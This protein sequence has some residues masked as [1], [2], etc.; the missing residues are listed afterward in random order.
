M[1][2]FSIIR[3]SLLAIS[4]LALSLILWL[5]VS[6]WYDAYLQRIDASDLLQGITLDDNLFRLSRDLS[7]ER[8]LIHIM[9][10]DSNSNHAVKKAALVE[11]QGESF[12]HYEQVLRDISI[13]L[14]TRSLVNRL[15]FKPAFVEE[16]VESL[17]SQWKDLNLKRE[18][19]LTQLSM[20]P[21]DR[22]ENLRQQVFKQFTASIDATQ[23]VKD[24]LRITQR[25]TELSIDQLETL[26][27]ANWY[28]GEDIASEASIISGIIL[29]GKRVT[30]TQLQMIKAIHS[31]ALENWEELNFYVHKQGATS[32]LVD[33]I[34]RIEERYFVEYI[35]LRDKILSDYQTLDSTP[36]WIDQWLFVVKRMHSQLDTLDEK[37]SLEV[38]TNSQEVE[39]HAVRR[40]IIDT[41]LV[42]ICLLI[43]AAVVATLKRIQHMAT[44]DALTGLPNRIRFE[45]LLDHEFKERKDYRIGVI[46]LDVYGFKRVNDRLGHSIGDQ[47]LMQVAS[48]LAKSTESGIVLA[49]LG[50]DEFAS[51]VKIYDDLESFT[52]T[53]E[54]YISVLAREFEVEGT[55][56]QIGS[57]IGL[58]YSSDDTHSA[59]EL[60]KNADFAM[61]QAK[62]HGKDC[63][64]LFDQDI[65]DKY[66]Y[67]IQLELE[68]R[69]AVKE[70]QFQLYYQPQFNVQTQKIDAV[71]A[72]IRWDHPEK[73]LVAPD[74]FLPLAEET[75]LLTVIG[76]W[77]LDEA[78]RQ[79]SVWNKGSLAG[80][81]IAANVSAAH[82]SRPGFVEY[83]ESTY[84]KHNIDP[85]SLELEI[86]ESALVDNME[87]VIETFNSLRAMNIELAID[88]FG[89]G[90][91]S[92]SYLQDL[93]VD[94]LKIDKS[95]IDRLD[96]DSEN[97]IA[98][99]IVMLAKACG[100]K[101]VAEGVE[102]ERQRSQISEFGC[103][104]IQGYFYSKPMESSKVPQKIAE[105]NAL[106]YSQR[107]A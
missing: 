52:N 89:T 33:T 78:C 101:T 34:G 65:S 11:L 5:S 44:H 16:Q 57:C 23:L 81:R 77:V 13:A 12:N 74:V 24:K 29:L 26:R 79:I 48:R 83:V 7:K 100:L 6:F 41:A 45:N 27:T 75:G 85:R 103:E 36:V 38:R 98:K 67:R 88:D 86:T 94:T 72:L 62:A 50:G 68:L 3:R 51:I 63:F 58:S 76:D 43:G 35:E 1:T 60:M 49:R 19:A 14:A 21:A 70:Q 106:H 95:F 22:D 25:R 82:F 37:I 46:I 102:T 107:A 9:L 28:F 93:P 18:I 55:R 92:L 42:L 73:G 8:D 47:L 56:V 71:E 2:Y 31:D 64:R 84:R 90:Y 97:S 4:T 15:A 69:E 32:G 39:A 30:S 17:R 99:T 54:Q 53:A 66:Q 96:E 61:Y 104:Y 10:T 80:I 59:T 91:S 87:S 40:L 20:P 105:I